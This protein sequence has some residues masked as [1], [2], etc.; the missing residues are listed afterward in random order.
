MSLNIEK[1][2][3]I[4][5]P[6][7]E[8]I[9]IAM[10]K[11]TDKFDTSKFSQALKDMEAKVEKEVA[12]A[13][14]ALP[15]AEKAMEW[16]VDFTRHEDVLQKLRSLGKNVITLMSWRGWWDGDLQCMYINFNLT[17]RNLVLLQSI[18]NQ[19]RKDALSLDVRQFLY[20]L[21]RRCFS[22]RHLTHVLIQ[23]S[24]D[25]AKPNY[26]DYLLS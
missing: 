5:D 17:T 13:K 12:E 11:F 2:Q 4:Q 23:W 20:V 9:K 10:S 7:V 22:V 15:L 18:A 3:I 21:M 16:I 24:A 1:T 26:Y 6:V 8:N 25:V 14:D 19:R